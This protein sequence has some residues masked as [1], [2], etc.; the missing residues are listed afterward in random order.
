M[1]LR[2]PSRS[3][4]PPSARTAPRIRRTPIAH[5]IATILLASAAGA[6]HA[7]HAPLSS[8]WAAARLNAPT[9]PRPTAPMTPGTSNPLRPG[10]VSDPAGTLRQPSVQQ[11]IANLAKAAAAISTEQLRQKQAAEAARNNPTAFDGLMPGGLQL[12]PGVADDP[13]APTTVADGSLW[14]NAELPTQ[15]V[16]DGRTTVEIEQT[17]NKAVLS[18]ETFN[19]G[20]NT[21]VHFDQ[22]AGNQPSGVNEWIAL[23]RINDPSGR[24]SQIFGQIK[25]EGSV[26]LLNRNGILFGAGSQVNTHSL[27]A[28]SLNLFSRDV[29]ESNR[30]FLEQGLAAQAGEATPILDSAADVQQGEIPG[31][32]RIEA[33]A[34][35]AAGT[36]GFSLIAAPNVYNDGS[37]RTK[38]GQAV[39]AAVL[40]VSLERVGDQVP[41][42]HLPLRFEN[43]GQFVTDLGAEGLGT[44]ENTG[45]I[46]STRGD[47]ILTGGVVR[48][49][50]VVVA[51]TGISRPGS[52][53]IAAVDY[54]ANSWVTSLGA[55]IGG[56]LEFHPDSLTAVLPEHDGETTTS[57]PSA[58]SVFRPSSAVLL[59]AQI[60]FQPDSLV[61]LPGGD[62]DITGLAFRQRFVDGE[63]VPQPERILIDTGAIISV[64][65]LPD[66]QLPMS[67]NLVTIP[68]I[69]QNELADSPLQRDGEL[70]REEIVIDS[71]VTGTRD[72]GLNWVGSPI[73][74]AGGYAEQ[75]RRRIDELLIDG[76][77][78]DISGPD[79]IMRPGSTL[80]LDGG[81]LHYLGG[82]VE[83][84]KLLGADGRIYTL[85]DADPMATY[86]GFAGEYTAEHSRWGVTE[87]FVNPLLS[88]HRYYE[89][90]YIHGG[91][92]GTLRLDIGGG[93]PDPLAPPGVETRHVTLLAG[94]IHANAWSGRYQVRFGEQAR[95]G[96]FEATA[97]GD[98]LIRAG[99]PD[100][101][102][103]FD[104]DSP[105]DEL[106]GT[107]LPPTDRNNPA[108]WTALSTDMLN[109]AGFSSV[110]VVARSVDN[111][112]T[113]IQIFVGEDADLHVQPGGAITL[114]GVRVD[115]LGSL[116]AES[117]SIAITGGGRFQAL[118][119][120]NV[121]AP[122]LDGGIFVGGD[123]RLS[124]RGQ[125]VNDSGL[126]G[127]EQAG[128]AFIDGG[129]ISLSSTQNFTDSP[130]SP[131]GRFDTSGSILLEDGAVLDVSGG[132]RILPDGS[133]AMHD[134]VPLGRG[135]DIALRTYVRTEIPPVQP[136]PVAA[137]HPAANGNVGLLHFEGAHLLADSLGGGGTLTLRARDVQ[138][139]G[140]VPADARSL[141]LDAGF[142]ENGSF[143][144][145]DLSAELD[146]TVAAGTQVRVS[147]RSFIPDVS[148]LLDAATGTD[149]HAGLVDGANARGALG[150][151]DP[152][153]RPATDFS[154]RG[155]DAVG[156]SGD[157]PADPTGPGAGTT[158]LDRGASLLL[159][160]GADVRLGSR[161]QLTVLGSIIAPG[162][163]ITLSGDTHQDSILSPP[164]AEDFTPTSLYGSAD[165]SVWVGAQSVLDVS[166]VALVDPFADA[167][168][169]PQGGIVPRT[170]RVLD[171]GSITQTNDGGY[172]VVE[173]GAQL[174]LSGARDRFDLPTGSRAQPIA[175]T[176]VWSDAG[177]LTLASSGG[178]FF[179]GTITAAGGDAGARGG[180][181]T[182]LP[183][184]GPAE[185]TSTGIMFEQAGSRTPE[186]LQPGQAVEPELAAP[187]GLMH[188]AADRLDG[189]GIDTLIAGDQSP[190]TVVGR[191][192]PQFTPGT[193]LVPIA[194]SGDVELSVERAL[195]LNAPD[196]VLLPEGVTDLAVAGG[197]NTV[198]LGAAYVGFNGYR[199]LAAA[200]SAPVPDALPAPAGATLSVDADFIDI[201]GQASL[202]NV[203]QANF[204][205]SGDLRF[206]TP[207]DHAFLQLGE[208]VSRERVPGELL[209]AGDIT[210]KAAQVY[211]ATGE[212]FIVRALGA[213]D[214]ETGE[215]A[216]TTIRFLGNGDSTAPL[217]A[218]GSLLVDATH[219]E[220][221]GT[222][223]AP[224]GRIVLG[225]G[226]P[227]DAA[228]QALFGD[229][230]LVATE[231][232]RLAEGSLT[233][234]ALEGQTVP[235]GST[236]DGLEWTFNENPRISGD[237]E[238]LT[239]PPQKLLQISGADV[240]L[241]AGATVDL[242]GG[243]DLQASEW[244]AG[245][246]G[247]RD[248]LSQYNISYADGD[249][250]TPVPLY[251]DERG[252]YAIVPGDQTL[253][254]AADPIL[255]RGQAQIEVGQAVYLSGVPGL[256]DGV[257]TLLPAKYAT[258]PGAYRVVQRTGTQ[259]SV[260]ANNLVM[261]DGTAVVAGW[262]ADALTGARDARSTS[263]EVQ[264]RTVWGQYSEYTT[265][266]A[267]SFF[268]ALAADDGAV[269]PQLPRDGG[270]LVLGA[271]AQLGLGATLDTAA[272][273]GGAAALVDIAA[274]AVQ[275]LGDGQTGL[276]GHIQ[277]DVDELNTLSASSLLIGG[278]RSQTADGLLIDALADSLVVSND[279]ADPL[280]G[281][282]ILLVA[283]A[284]D[285]DAG[286]TGLRID[287]GSVIEASG[288]LPGT[289]ARPIVIGQ[290]AD[291]TGAGGVSGDG[292]LL[293]VSNAGPA[294][295]L[296][297]N[298]PAFGE[299][300]G[301]LEIGDGARLDGGASLTLDATGDTR[302]DPSAILRGEAIAANSGRISFAEGDAAAGLDGLVIGAQTLEQFAAAEQVSL[303]SYG[304]MDFF[305]DVLVDV[306]QSLVL[307]AGTFA[308]DGGHVRLRA[309]SLTLANELEAAAGPDAG[310]AGSGVLDLQVDEV[311][312]GAG[313]A[314]LAG[315]GRVVADAGE[316]IVGRE[317]GS[318]DFGGIDVELRAP[319]I[320][321]DAGADTALTTTG[322]LTLT[323]TAGEVADDAP[324]GGAI[325][326]TG[327]S[328]SG[329]ALI[330]ANAGTVELRATDGDLRLDAGAV[331][332][333]SGVSREF[334]DAEGYAPG[335]QIGL[336]ADQGVVRLAGGATLNF[337][338][339]SGGGNAGSLSV[340]APTRTAELL[341]TLSGG[342]ENG[343]GGSLALDVG[344]AVDLD[345][346][347]GRLV[348][349][350]VDGALDIR[351]RTGNLVLSEGGTLAAR[352]VTLTA[353]GG[354]A[355]QQ[356]D[357]A[358]GNIVIDGTIDACGTT[359][360]DIALWG[361]HGVTV[362]GRL[363]ATGSS[364][365]RRGGEVT[366]GT[367]GRHDGTLHTGYGH[368][369]VQAADAG[370]IAIGEG[371]LIDVSG[372][373]AGGLSGGTVDFRAPL[374]ADGDVN[375]FIA[376]GATIEGARE[377][378]LEA[379]AVWST[380]DAIIGA[381]KHFDGIVDPAGW[382][383][384]EGNLRPGRW[385]D[386]HGR[387]IDPPTS[388]EQ[389]AEYLDLYYFTPNRP[390]KAHQNFY[391]YTGG[392]AEHARPGTLMRFVQ[393]PGFTFE[394]RFA[395]IDG[396][397]ARAGIE[398]Q[399]PDAE[400]HGGA[401]RVLTNWNLGSG[402]SPT[403]L[404]FRTNGV[405]PVLTLRA[406]GDVEIDASI[407]DGFYN[408]SSD[409]GGSGAVGSDYEAA[410]QLY[411]DTEVE[412]ISLT[413]GTADLGEFLLPPEQITS[414]DPDEIA[415]YY[416]QYINLVEMI[417][418][419]RDP[420]CQDICGS[421]LGGFFVLYTPIYG[422]P[423][424]TFPDQPLPP[425]DPINPVTFQAYVPAYE[426][427]ALAMFDFWIQ[428]GAF[429]LPTLTT[430]VLP[431]LGPLIPPPTPSDR[432]P[433]L[434]A[435]ADN[436][437][438][439]AIT[440]LAGGDSSSY[441]FI[442]GADLDSAAPNAVR[443]DADGDIVLDGHTTYRED[444]QR[445]LVLPTVVRTGTGEIEF[446]AARD[447]RF[448]DEIA[449]A[450]V[451][452]AGRPAEGTTVVHEVEIRT[453][454]DV[455]ASDQ[456][457][458]PGLVVTGQ[459]NP[460]AAGDITLSAGRDILGN[461]QLYDTDG[462]LTGVPDNYVGQ[463]WWPWMQTGNTVIDGEL[464]ASS[465]NFGGFAQGV[466]SVGGDVAVDAGRDIRELSVSLPT[467]WTLTPDANDQQL[468]TY[469]GG[470]LDV[471]AGR[472]VLGGDYFVS[473]G[474]GTLAAGGSLGAAFDLQA[475]QLDS[476]TGEQTRLLSTPV[477]PVLALQDATWQVTAAQDAQ[478]GAVVNP[479]YS[480]PLTDQ[481][482]LPMELL[483]LENGRVT[484]SQTYGTDSG[485]AVT[486]VGGDVR[487]GTQQLP[488]AL[489]AYGDTI[490]IVAG[491]R[492]PNLRARVF[493]NTLPAS[494]ALTALTGDLSV[495]DGGEL[496][497][498]AEGG[499]TLLAGGDIRLFSTQEP[500][501]AALRM[502]DIDAATF[503]P[504]PFD[505]L[506]DDSSRW[507]PGSFDNGQRTRRANLHRDDTDPV[508]IYAAGGDIVGGSAAGDPEVVNLTLILPKPAQIR[509]G[510]DIVDLDFRGQN[511]LD[512]DVTSI[513]AGRDL[514]YTPATQSSAIGVPWYWLEL[515]GSGLFEVQAGRNLGPVTSANEVFDA[516]FSGV[517]P[518]SA[519]GIRTIGN[520][521][522][523]GLPY[524]GASIALRF[525][526]AP[527]M[528]T[529]EFAQIYLDPASEQAAAYGE[530]L[531]EF[532]E[533]IERDRRARAGEDG[534]AALTVDQ[535]WQA[536]RQQPL[537]VQQ[538]LV[539]RVFLDVLRQVGVDYNNPDSPGFN[540]YAD[541]YRAI[542]TLFPA[543]RGY[544]ANNLEGGENG[545]AEQVATG[546]LD[547]RGSTVQTQQGGDI[548][549][550]GPGGSVL[551]GS[552]SA[553]PV[554]RGRDGSVII[555]PNQQGILTLSDGG[556]GIFTDLDVQLAQSRIF[557]QRGGDLLI[558]SSNGDINA[559]KGSKTSSEIPPVSY[560]CDLDFHCRIDARGQVSGAG[561]A[562][563]QT[564]P[565]A[566]AG[567]AVLVAPRGTVDAGDAGIRVS[568][569]LIVAA[570][571]VANADNI[572]VQGEEIGIPTVAPVNIGAL[573]AASNA[574]AA[575][576][577]AAQDIARRQQDEARDRAG[578]V[579]IVDVVG[580]GLSST[581]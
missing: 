536:F 290:E 11:T 409:G 59:G 315:F 468:T 329:D 14:Q 394:G 574:A 548:R 249:S 265:A 411:S 183:L 345:A 279:A 284:G 534:A 228:T 218:G 520:R 420:G 326:L 372:G 527:G 152:Y 215:R 442:A 78:I 352:E 31:D 505:P 132:G 10:G 107:E 69:G 473:K 203:A 374:L 429:V 188:F 237:G 76:G 164:P 157:D 444:G 196:Y 478:I 151:L 361:R 303:R 208:D 316:A 465:I 358:N 387:R 443:A 86:V 241:D 324:L 533:Q 16:K 446:V 393:N 314:T 210:F 488:G 187:S 13:I 507:N 168:G 248:V 281:S 378:G 492:Q 457:S 238:A 202:R 524:E 80:N 190:D 245:T 35:V 229:R 89:T 455:P 71:R 523:A 259:D 267:D 470:N 309:D 177:S 580:F 543:E 475:V 499:L 386:H 532:M 373:S 178:L 225:V 193:P 184:S 461:R 57:G 340:D 389:L 22:T 275:I 510:R 298:V 471:S 36:G 491:D 47:I 503:L 154:L 180:T 322:A 115:V 173:E 312:F 135:G 450:S 415:Q 556:I 348:D 338:A 161:G 176:D 495:E 66:V 462:S 445:D 525:G 432:T 150:I 302:V 550:L 370:V 37:V 408:F 294:Q 204:T 226:D 359:G 397:V 175:A 271:S 8:G 496:A 274:Q 522:N 169:T 343:V 128:G 250:G 131:T 565:G 346:L 487:F 405:A 476:R 426:Q 529:A 451:Y 460:E 262:F 412:W 133:L 72:D 205:S 502:L 261:P 127:D 570:Q 143:G 395:D 64:T 45:L 334:Y 539:D 9:A 466:L 201:G 211:P 269:A 299:A 297:R 406:E 347:A 463:Y 553:P 12:D 276:D 125:W 560:V 436:P 448:A 30:I 382:Y 578:S 23:N 103:G 174:N 517:F 573:N 307:S 452:T 48:Q 105:I 501:D 530:L 52:V 220:Q 212:R 79:L 575:A 41:V 252:V 20:S 572:Q 483:D 549:I 571:Q 481:N 427:Y 182:L 552:L 27:L 138:I 179:D 200:A 292:A 472:D 512:S 121:D 417:T 351:T 247:S 242:S 54:T 144:A 227:Q 268:S 482:H 531:A 544:T 153:Y 55:E 81:Y 146:A 456:G 110:S 108:G 209:T 371:A 129:S 469:G 90:D 535:A 260:A 388:P 17:D 29:A 62:L 486:A 239:A 404:D 207:A 15:S 270:Q 363:L 437:I 547:M 2:P 142:F 440:S 306:N 325:A 263:F 39:L 189:S 93:R 147:Q 277:L 222:V 243:G 68:R 1:T 272:A 402:G 73:L 422:L 117:G 5:A 519:G 33:G 63:P 83:T 336:T 540:Q 295:I 197:D 75:V 479:S 58:D 85:A 399:N 217:S 148:G 474:E 134:G 32:I 145:Y 56:I 335:G 341:G 273:E 139:G 140:E 122:F 19:V 403:G 291:D 224:A 223:R 91:N 219:I 545:A 419:Q 170:G 254:A 526:V 119:D 339:D 118:G 310:T 301:L 516:G 360:G 158:L 320:Q 191:D 159:D 253:I 42:N 160:P 285:P 311:V 521:D 18:W 3:R 506:T 230:D 319:V 192:G 123:A 538:T 344:G 289:G 97:D 438:P 369:N 82:M 449:P 477:A 330:R 213:I 458:T 84:R 413:G 561:I 431:I 566:P 381:G 51:T 410:L 569:N 514:Y 100:V 576:S 518:P 112:P 255:N 126:L 49:A 65:G 435:S 453:F 257:Y 401:I 383:D 88:R 181:L 283:K 282:E 485:V 366:L 102:D 156:R 101:P 425:I 50:G 423:V 70:Y 365:A 577:Q 418:L 433:S 493:A 337:S 67:A 149:I 21:T 172:V 480:T 332:D 489:F 234:V 221:A 256:A 94:D 185:F 195:H 376:D 327:G 354:A 198:S 114:S 349:S 141:H 214:A 266:S 364:A 546:S 61:L 137:Q 328:L 356:R 194:F 206:H 559:G 286:G 494:L 113:P 60:H 246:G 353:D 564:V 25:A 490:P 34:D 38:D 109:A 447:L 430:P 579:I 439:F 441:R 87:T 581:N 166:G 421:I 106:P 357:A 40:K 171:G 554:V 216:E 508:R 467:T 551:V 385:T 258:L 513:T 563:L 300:M 317:R 111:N 77:T 280:R 124:A 240:A 416:G 379:Y 304:A 74:N 199:L 557:T 567:D 515:G 288:E 313:D 454:P 459:V 333:V 555:G 377:V 464:V 44:L 375:V 498:S 244:I 424:E 43:V 400:L 384:R 318:F 235:Y 136:V 92:A 46:T 287:A 232:V 323:R 98:V 392:D 497:P 6:V 95:G 407:S 278:T 233:S 120:P 342:A 368:Q 116:T 558:W 155:G 528:A 264:S 350:G 104:I 504:S 390:N 511:F 500:R 24:P 380:A 355:S 28:S 99:R 428:N 293:R 537:S 509:A 541:G 434:Q 308:S 130:D 26:Y 236:V 96:S 542:N 391:G 396:F 296:R 414:G 251:P 7:G 321:A 568:G 4:R 186:G 231:S 484:D 167:V 367:S 305:D 562:T 165:K 162:G 53:R 362:N 398:L 331:V 163:S